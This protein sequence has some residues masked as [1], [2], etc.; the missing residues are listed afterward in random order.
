MGVVGIKQLVRLFL[1]LLI[2]ILMAGADYG[3]IQEQIDAADPGETITLADKTYEENIIIDKEVH[4][5][6]DEN[7]ILK[8]TSGQPAITIT[9]TGASVTSLTIETK[10]VGVKLDEADENILSRLEI[11][12]DSSSREHGIELWKSDKNEISHSTMTDVKDGIYVERSNDTRILQN[13][14][15]HSR[16]GFHLMFTNN[17]LL[18]ENTAAQNVNGM[19]IMGT[20]GTVVE[21]NL[22]KDNQK[23]AQSL[24]MLLFDVKNATIRHNTIVNN[25]VGVFIDE[26]SDNEITFNDIT[27]NYIGLQMKQAENNQIHHNSFE[28]NVVQGQAE[29]SAANATSENYW[30]DHQGL[31]ITGGNASDLPYEVDPFFLHITNKFPPFQLLFDSPGMSFLETLIHTP[32]EERLIDQAPLLENPLTIART[33]SESR[34]LT[35]LV[36]VMALLVS[37]IIIIMGVKKS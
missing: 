37:S 29:G 21:H 31:N 6:G 18:K 24:G 5:I 2:V 28:A 1:L 19:M 16:Y 33:R 4:L 23:N 25:R 10:G 26:A 36:S 11:I 12:G 34:G 3:S 13:T 8:N 22:L 30:G 35:I 7:T 17:S 9:A 15:S 32:Q 20:N 14:T 27:R